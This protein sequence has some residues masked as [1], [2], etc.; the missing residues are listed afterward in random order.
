MNMKKIFILAVTAGVLTACSINPDGSI[1]W[2]DN[3]VERAAQKINAGIQGT[4]AALDTV[5]GSGSKTGKKKT[6]NPLDEQVYADM[7]IT[8][9]TLLDLGYIRKNPDY[10]KNASEPYVFTSLNCS[11][12]KQCFRNTRM[13]APR[14]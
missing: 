7:K 8:Y 12:D 4:N 11:K 1:N 2:A 6:G 10:P 5:A 3:P 9:R 14:P 13:I